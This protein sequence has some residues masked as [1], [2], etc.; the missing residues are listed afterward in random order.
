MTGTGNIRDLRVGDAA[1]ILAGEVS[2][3]RAGDRS[4]GASELWD[5]ARRAAESVGAN[6]AEG[7]GRSTGPDRRRCFVIA[8]G[9]LRETQHH[10]RRC[11]D[12]ALITERQFLRLIGLSSVTRRMRDA[13][14]A[15]LRGA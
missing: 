4:R 9:S 1:R 10:L 5:Q 14:I 2:R 15:R 3:A 7:C 13:L 12:E 11:R 8:Q 6:I